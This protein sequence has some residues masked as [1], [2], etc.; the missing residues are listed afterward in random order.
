MILWGMQLAGRRMFV[1]HVISSEFQSGYE[2]GLR[3][4]TLTYFNNQQWTDS[5]FKNELTTFTETFPIKPY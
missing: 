2:Q 3:K 1:H 4:N 5:I